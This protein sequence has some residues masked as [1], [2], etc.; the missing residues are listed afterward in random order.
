MTAA[1]WMTFLPALVLVLTRIS[2]LM[3]SAPVFSSAAIPPQVKIALTVILSLIIFPAVYPQMTNIPPS[4]LGISGAVVTELMIGLTIGLAANLFFAGIELGGEMI[5]QQMGLGLANVFNPMLESESGVVAQVYVMVCMALL[6][7][8]NGHHLLLGAV[9]DSYRFLPPM[10]QSMD[11]HVLTVIRSLL[12]SSF[13]IA[14]KLA[15]PSILLLFLVSMFMGFLG[16]TVPQINILVVGFPL[17]IS[18]GLIGMVATFGL[19]LT[20]FTE[21]YRDLVDSMADLIH[22]LGGT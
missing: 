5:S 20:V 13:V 12:G 22:G 15:I 8:F 3:L 7:V 17:R 18:V 21:G 6:L 9:L 2:G 10:A 16:R 11:P 1:L 14:M 19:T 4:L